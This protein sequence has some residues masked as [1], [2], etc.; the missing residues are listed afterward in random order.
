MKIAV[1]V[2]EDTMTTGVCVSFGRAPFFMV[3]DSGTESGTFYD[4]GAAASEGGAGIKAAQSLV[5]LGAEVL[6]TPRCGDNAAQV[7]RAAGI[8]L[9]KTKDGSALDNIGAF[10]DDRLPPLTESTR[11]LPRAWAALTCGSPCSAARA[12]R[13]RRLSP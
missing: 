5:D 10:L 7:L 8:R 6:L 4:N 13:A 12:A 3:F 2:D 9:F 1:P 11:R